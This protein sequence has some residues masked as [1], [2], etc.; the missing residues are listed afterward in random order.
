MWICVSRYQNVSILDFNGA[1]VME[2]VSGDS[3][4]CMTCKA[5]VKYNHQQQTNNQ[6]FLQPRCPS[7]HPTN[8]VK[9]LKG[10]NRTY[11]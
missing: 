2:V 9:A 7:C 6:L 10:K 5:P 1:K 11:L 8:S 3:W 4:S